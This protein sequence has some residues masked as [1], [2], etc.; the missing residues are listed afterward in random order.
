M[1]APIFIAVHSLGRAARQSAV[2]SWSNVPTT[3]NVAKGAFSGNA[4]VFRAA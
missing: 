2:Q 1:F 3:A 4:Q